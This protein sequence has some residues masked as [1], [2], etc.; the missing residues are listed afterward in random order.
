MS[1]KFIGIDRHGEVTGPCR[2]VHYSAD[3]WGQ[4]KPVDFGWG[5]SL[6]FE[7][8]HN[9]PPQE[10]AASTKTTATDQRWFCRGLTV[11]CFP[12]RRGHVSLQTESPLEFE[13][14]GHF[15]RR[16]HLRTGFQK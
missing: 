11:P 12:G 16:R 10:R 2:I 3:G 7:R 15:P 4:K 8:T 1:L 5:L 6:V 9:C 13:V 14:V